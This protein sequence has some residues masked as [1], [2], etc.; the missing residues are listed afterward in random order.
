[1]ASSNLPA[2]LPKLATHR[3]PG[4]RNNFPNVS[5]PVPGVDP[6]PRQAFGAPFNH[7]SSESVGAGA[8]RHP[9]TGQFTKS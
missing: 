6:A 2:S 1:M 3:D 7:P 5:G 9:A 4:F 8:D